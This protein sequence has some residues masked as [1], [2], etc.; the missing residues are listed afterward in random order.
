[1]IPFAELIFFL[2]N[3]VAGYPQALELKNPQ[4]FLSGKNN[5]CFLKKIV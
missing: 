4:Y 5:Q 1:M 3:K 2:I